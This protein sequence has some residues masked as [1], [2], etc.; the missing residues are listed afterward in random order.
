MYIKLIFL[1]Y[2]FTVAFT[3]DIKRENHVLVLTKDNFEGAVKDKNVL[4]E[5][6]APWCGHCKALEP[7]YAKAAESLSKE[8]S[9]LL[10]AKVDAT[11]ET[12]LAEQH[13][14][15]GYP[16]IK[17]FREGK[18]MEYSGGRT[19]D[20]IIRWLKKK[21]GPP[22]TELTAETAKSF[23]EGQ[24]VVV[25]G[26][27]KDQDSADAKVFKS[28]ASEM[29]DFN[30][31]ITSDDAVYTELK[32]S[33]DGVTLFKKFDE[34]RNDFEEEYTEEALKKFL[35]SN[36]LPLVVEF[37]HE[38]AQKIFG[39]DIKAH[40]LLFISKS[41]SDYESK[42]T[43]FRKIAKEFKG[44]VLFVTIDIDEDDHERIIEFFGLK[45][46]EAPTMRLI[47]LEEEMSKFK[48]ETAG[49]DESDIRDFVNGVM[50]G[51]IKQHLLSE[52]V[53]EGW[54]KEPVKVLV[55]KNFNE[56]AFDKSKNVL[57]EFYAPWCGHCKQLAPIYDE[58]GEKYKDNPSV[59][60]AKMDATAN[61]L[62]HTKINSFPTIKLY[63]KD[64]NEVVEYNGER[65][66]EGINKFIETDGEYGKAAPD[67]IKKPKEEDE[68][69]E[70][71]DEQAKRDEL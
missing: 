56:V 64:T 60:I 31:G 39:G 21:T 59:V 7:E 63:K 17:F 70:K 23:V 36:S 51:K 24:E 61:E 58:L 45:K 9:E 67:E 41:S 35:K 20:D 27:F 34:G 69:E 49:I 46:E 71:D 42:L 43:T 8:G 40:N 55:G 5:F 29:D 3:D 50:D 4:V 38:T 37:N 68:E 22:A 47:K 1:T 44:K 25:V 28:V 53:P 57:V 12:E 14:V 66:L 65:T 15:R 16:T 6:Y 48:P 52:D 26:F 10:L 32:A 2:L 13:G 18:V 30:F 33:K 19:A 11:A 62:E 54:D